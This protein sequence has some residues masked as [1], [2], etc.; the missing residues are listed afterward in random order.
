MQYTKLIFLIVLFVSLVGCGEI[1]TI[2]IGAEQTRESQRDILGQ[3]I[4]HPPETV[5][6]EW[7]YPV[8]HFNLQNQQFMLY[9]TTYNNYEVD[10][11][12]VIIP[13]PI[14]HNKSHRTYVFSM[15]YD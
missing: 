5:V 1:I 10:I 4:G 13:I 8:K 3:L 7:G 11:P 2:P 9:M 12:W 6:K 15:P 14:P